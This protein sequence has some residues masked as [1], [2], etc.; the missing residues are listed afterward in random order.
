MLV[1]EEESVLERELVCQGPYCVS[2]CEIFQGQDLYPHF[3]DRET[4]SQRGSEFPS[5]VL[6]NWCEGA[7]F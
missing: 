6:A 7:G 3:S 4:G 2:T 1:Q 5:D